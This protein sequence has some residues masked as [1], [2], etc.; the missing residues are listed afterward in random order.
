VIIE[1]GGGTMFW[2]RKRKNKAVRE[3][4]GTL[5]QYMVNKQ[6]V[7]LD[8]L[9]NLRLIEREVRIGDEPV[10]LTMFRIFHPAATKERGVTID[11]FNSLDSYPELILYEGYYQVTDDR[12]TNIRIEKKPEK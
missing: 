10:A 9:H 11:D 1:E 12:A 2:R 5:F 8:L 6:H 3:I 7:P 4:K